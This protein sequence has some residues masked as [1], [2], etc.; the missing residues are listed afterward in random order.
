MTILD[1]TTADVALQILG[2]QEIGRSMVEVVLD[3]PRVE[4]AI[5]EIQELTPEHS[6]NRHITVPTTHPTTIEP[7]VTIPHILHQP[8]INLTHLPVEV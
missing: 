1:L 4:T 6:I 7:S 5:D 8:L 2:R 3:H